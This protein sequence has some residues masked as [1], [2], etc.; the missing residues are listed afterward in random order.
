LMLIST[1]LV[2]LFCFLAE[3]RK[4][5]QCFF[6]SDTNVERHYGRF[7]PMPREVHQLDEAKIRRCDTIDVPTV[8]CT[9]LCFSLKVSSSQGKRNGDESPYG[10]S[11]GCSSQVL[12]QDLGLEKPGCQIIEILLNTVP[13]YKV[14]AEYCTCSG[15]ECNQVTVVNHSRPKGRDRTSY[16]TEDDEGRSINHVLY[17]SDAFRLPI[18]LSLAT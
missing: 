10:N 8:N 13:P 11:F 6:C 15:D 4:I 9:D 12:R 14:Q 16:T 3:S 7:F 1:F 5:R 18:L 17:S 2:H